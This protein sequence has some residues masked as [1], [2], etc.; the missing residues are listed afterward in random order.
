MDFIVNK[1]VDKA[2]E[3]YDFSRFELAKLKYMLEVIILNTGEFILFLG[4]FAY[5]GKVA[6]LFVAT[7]VLLS[8]RTFAGGFHFVKFRYCVIVSLAALWLVIMVLPVIDLTNNGLLEVLLVISLLINIALAPVSKRKSGQ[9]PKVR[10]IFKGIST[11]I[12]LAISYF[13][14]N[15]QDSPFAS[16]AVWILFF[17]SVQLIIGKGMI[18][19]E[20]AYSK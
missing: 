20:K 3:N 14:L 11:A 16:I 1:I 17:Q 6:E 9:T 15:Y 12:M 7:G 8:V 13:I 2:E 4:V 10:Y 19:N 18:T 5:L